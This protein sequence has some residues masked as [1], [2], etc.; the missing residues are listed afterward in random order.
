MNKISYIVSLYFLADLVNSERNETFN[1][2]DYL[3]LVIFAGVLSLIAAYGIGCNDVANS[4]ASS[5]GSKA[6]T[7]KQAVVLDRKSVV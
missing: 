2:E 7:I 3:W 1:S 5:V 4:F 6:V